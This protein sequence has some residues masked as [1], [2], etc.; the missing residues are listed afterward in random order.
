MAKAKTRAAPQAPAPTP[1]KIGRPPSYK[2]EFAIQA[3]K[4]CKL[5][6]TDEEAAE[7]FGVSVRTLYRWKAEHEAFCQALKVG[8]A[9]ADDRVERSLYAR[10]VGFERDA[11]K[12]FMPA[13]A[14]QP[15]VVPFK[16][17]VAP[18]TT[19]CIFWLKNRRKTEWRD[20]IDHTLGGD[21]NGTPVPVAVTVNFVAAKPKVTG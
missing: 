3:Q 6:A 10:A 15:V 7:F 14:V 17:H 9:E 5:G 1:A 20:R 13:N 2:P 21:P 11:V 16:E 18:D 12:I 19:A 4:L 8:K